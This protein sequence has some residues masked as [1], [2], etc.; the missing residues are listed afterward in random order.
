MAAMCASLVAA[1]AAAAVAKVQPSKAGLARLAAPNAAV[2]SQKTVSNGMRTRQMLVWTPVDNKFFETFSYLPP[3][4]TREIAKQIDYIVN[5]GFIP[6][7]E[8]ASADQAYTASGSC[9]RLGNASSGYYDNRYWTMYK[10]PMFGCT[11]PSQVLKEIDNCTKSFPD[12]YIR[13]VAFD[14]VRQVQC[15]GFLVHR[16]DSAHEFQAPDRRSI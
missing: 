7:L 5:N 11:D 6:S 8:F 10:L 15:A 12:A 3:L 1:P 4:S 13:I 2:F 16:P 14:Q 9:I